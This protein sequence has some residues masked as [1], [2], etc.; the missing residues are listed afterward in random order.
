VAAS[1]AT[2]DGYIVEAIIPWSILGITPAKDQ[3]YGFAF[4]IS[5]D[6]NPDK[7]VQ[8]SLVSNVSTRVLTDPTTWGNLV[9]IRP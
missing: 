8:Q 9:L 1:A 2:A 3:R 7:A 4:T 6:D 5:D